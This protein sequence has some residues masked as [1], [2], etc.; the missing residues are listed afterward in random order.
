MGE[1]MPKTSLHLRFNY[2]NCRHMEAAAYI[3]SVRP[4]FKNALIIAAIEAYR[5]S[6]PCGI[7]YPEL[8]KIQRQ[9][10][11]GFQPASPIQSNLRMRKADI[12]TP[13]APEL[14]RRIETPTGDVMDQTIS[15]FDL[16]DDE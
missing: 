14:E 16:N 11:I 13:I 5:E 6:H 10:W 2:A 15:F 7:D 12:L 4:R 8:E 1:N 3:G 9:S